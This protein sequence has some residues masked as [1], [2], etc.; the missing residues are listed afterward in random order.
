MADFYTPQQDK[1]GLEAPTTAGGDLPTVLLI[2]DSISIGYTEP[3][4]ELLQGVCAVSRAPDNCGDTRRGLE[5]LAEWLGTGKWDLI[6]F[7]WGLHDLCYRHP[8]ATAYGNRDK[9]RGAISVP[10]DQYRTNLETLVRQLRATGSRLVWAGTTVVPEGE[11]GRHPGD[12]LRY[13]AAAA[14]IMATHGIPVNDLHALTA[15]FGPEMFTGP[16]D[17][18]FTEA[19]SR[20]LARQVAACIRRH[21]RLGGARV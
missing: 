13:N 20:A 10:L 11:P 6:H 16:G 2:G 21:L 14:E 7:N 18:H 4:R 12:E 3:V 17:V 5:K 19:A 9:V 1:A 15:R 8:E